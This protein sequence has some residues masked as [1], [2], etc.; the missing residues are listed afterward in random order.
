MSFGRNWRAEWALD[1]A[2]TYLNHGTVGAP[3]RRV[4]AAQQ[5]IRDEVEKQPS[6]FILR[7]TAKLNHEL[8]RPGPSRMRLAAAQVAEFVGARSE[9]LAFVDNATTGVNTVLRSIPFAPGD[10]ILVTD[11]TYGAV[12]ITASHIA[13]QHGATVRTATFPAPGAAPEAYV[14][15]I[16]AALTPRTRIAVL[17]HVTSDT[18]LVL[19]LARMAARCRAAGVPVL[20]DGAH[21]PGAIPL[22][23]PSLGVDWYT[24]NLHKWAWSPRSCAILWASAERQK[25]LHP[26]VISWCYG[27][28]FARE[29]DWVGT[30]DPS[31]ALAA[32]EGLAMMRELGLSEVRAYNHHIAW[33]GAQRLAARWGTEFRTPES[34]IGTMATL[35]LPER[36]GGS[37]EDAARLRDALLF[38][39]HIEIQLHASAGRL[40]VRISG[41]I[42]N[43]LA[44][45]DRLGEAVDARLAKAVSR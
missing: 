36:A 45:V 34:M 26:L 40:H 3:P 13:R 17:D 18:A 24:G 33:S 8:L 14:E 21:A 31:N 42:Y 1:P 38:E 35:P 39:D 5:A 11:H 44:D 28:G 15:A 23:L 25:D 10:E 12:A 30:R 37:R 32:P 4:L 29:F 7:E 27:E 19:P 2:I 20:V 43:D 41:Q 16:G 6:R 22:D 9:D